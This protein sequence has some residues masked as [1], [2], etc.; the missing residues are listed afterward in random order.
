MSKET[1]IDRGQFTDVILIE[2]E[3]GNRQIRK[4]LRQEYAAQTQAAQLTNEYKITK[5]LQIKGLRKALSFTKS[6]GRTTLVLEYVDGISL[7]TYF[8]RGV[9]IA[10]FLDI[11]CAIMQVVVEMHQKSV[12]H[13]DLNPN[14]ILI[15]EAQKQPYIIDFGIASTFSSK[16][17]RNVRADALEG[18]LA[19]MA[20]E[21]TGR[22]NRIIDQRSDLYSLGVTFYELLTSKLPFFSNDPS[23]L[24]HAH[25]A[26][27]PI[28]PHKL[29]SQVPN[30]LS[31]LVIKLLAKSAEERYQSAFGVLE[32]LKKIK[33]NPIADFELAQDDFNST[34]A[35]KQKLYGREDELRKLLSAYTDVC[36]G[37][38]RFLTIGGY[39]GA[40]KS[41]LV[42]E[43]H[44]PVTESNGYFI[45]GKFDQFKRDIPYY[46]W[47]Q[48]FR[49][50]SNW[51]LSE[52]DAQ[53]MVWQT[54]IKEAVKPYGKMLTDLV[55]QL[56][57]LIGKQTELPTM[58]IVEFQSAFS[59]TMTQFLQVVASAEHPLVVFIDDVQWAD[60]ASLNLIK[61]ILSN[62]DCTHLLLLVAFRSN[63]IT[64]EH[65]L[66]NLFADLKKNGVETHELDLQNL[67]A[68]H[69]KELLE[70]ALRPNASDIDGL[71]EII[72]QKTQ[73]NAFFVTQFLKT[74][75]EC[76]LLYLDHQTKKWQWHIQD[77]LKLDITDNV[78]D[79]LIQKINKMNPKA[80]E[81]L[82]A[83]ACFG[84]RFDLN[85]LAQMLQFNVQELEESLGWALQEQLIFINNNSV[86]FA[87]DRIQQAFYEISHE[88]YRLQTHA[89]IGLFI[90]E[91]LAPELR[92]ARIFDYIDHL[93]K[94]V[95][96]LPADKKIWLAKL[97]LVASQRAKTAN[98]YK[99]ALNY[100]LM[101]ESLL[102]S[103]AWQKDYQTALKTKQLIA[104]ILLLKTKFTQ[105][106]AH[107]QEGLSKTQ[108]LEDKIAFHEIQIKA[109]IAQNK[110][111]KAVEYAR[112][113]LQSLGVSLP[114]NPSLIKVGLTLLATKLA[115]WGKSSEDILG[116]PRMSDPKKLAAMR[117]M[118][119]IDYAVYASQKELFPIHIMLQLQISLK[120]GNSAYSPMAYATFG[121]I[122]CGALK[123]IDEG[124][125][126][127]NTAL[128]LLDVVEGNEVK[129]M[130]YYSASV[131]TLHWKLHIL[132]AL[133]YLEAAMQTGR[134]TGDL[135][136][137][138]LAAISDIYYSIFASTNLQE[139]LEKAQ[140]HRLF[141]ESTKQ[142]S[143]LLFLNIYHTFLELLVKP[144]ADEVLFQGTYF[145]SQE[146]SK[147]IEGSKNDAL[148]SGYY[149]L[150]EMLLVYY[151]QFEKAAP[152]FQLTHKYREGSLGLF[153]YEL[154]CW[155]ETMLMTSLLE[156]GKINQAKAV[157]SI[158][159]NIKL[160]KGVEK[161][162]PMNYEHLR[163]SAEAE[164][165]RTQGDAASALRLYSKAI[166]LAA[167]NQYPF[168]E[169]KI[170]ERL[171]E[172]LLNRK[173]TETGE[174]HL[175]KAFELYQNLGI[176]GKV[177]ALANAYPSLLSMRRGEAAITP[178]MGTITR[179]GTIMAGGGSSALDIN[180]IIKAS[181]ILSGEVMR[182]RLIE[183]LMQLVIEN[184]GAERGLLFL[185]QEGTLTVEA[186]STLKGTE[187]FKDSTLSTIGDASPE[188]KVPE[189]LINYTFR[190]QQTVLLGDAA[191]KGQF[192]S[193]SYI[194]QNK[195][196]SVLCMPLV[197]QGKVSGVLY[198]ENNLSTDFFTDS[199]VELLNMLSTQIAISLE[200][201]LL[202][203]N[204]EEKVKARTIEV[205]KQKSEI[206]QQ[207][208]ELEKQN[209]NIT[210]SI[211]YAKRIQE[212]MLPNMDEINAALPKNFVYFRPRDIV[213]GDFY[214]FQDLEDLCL[215]AAVDCTG[216]GVPGAFMSLIG[217]DLLHEI[218]VSRRIIE[219][220]QI[221]KELHKGVTASLRQRETDNRD[222]MDIA[223]CVIHRQSPKSSTYSHLVF[224]GAHNPLVYIQ[225]GTLQQI[226]G[227]NLSIG[228]RTLPN[229]VVEYEATRID[230]TSPT[231]FYIFSD[232][233]QDQFGGKEGR[234]FMIKRMK[235][236]FEQVHQL[237]HS[238]Q[239]STLDREI[240]AWKQNHKQT[241]DILVIG[242]EIG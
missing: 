28:P 181:E 216:H 15:N 90:Y 74:L 172:L 100:S 240:S 147:T 218:V 30:M 103:D 192:T 214:W 102:P 199:R 183:K 208:A 25:L 2:D 43:I 143:P 234:K 58:N 242:F 139:L 56:E 27:V 223:L 198:L 45:E 222:G 123:Q 62:K 158:K 185:N 101:A 11:A 99:A 95:G 75:D 118:T 124:Y 73:G 239:M 57:L 84:N 91:Q 14:N 108:N 89:K 238:E 133:P 23:E 41:S 210:A 38:A 231:S 187:L 156:A 94:A 121:G 44:K 152:L 196:K 65:P 197:N 127:A 88:E 237:P 6:G 160:L 178:R 225:N 129:A 78:V 195:P 107:I 66:N 35:L 179:A 137:A 191:Y 164:L 186:E 165:A 145:A 32:D 190:S 80:L 128:K 22:I 211:N 72:L 87:H 81:T 9:S 48:A 55:P 97:N 174:F 148:K 42:H 85:A 119:S 37:Q 194:K 219:P 125:K 50:L 157:S 120:Y 166:E 59:R 212:A 21:Q 176:L 7:N 136:F 228:G 114:N 29:V 155:L 20:P 134:T 204:L 86:K 135:E 169:C 96:F 12:I 205:M 115:L 163:F 40:G 150:Y 206:E 53:L 227:S 159:K 175:Q 106:E 61:A 110:L 203:E 31:K 168:F 180:T 76:D 130:T 71:C 142:E 79:L 232:G 188:A 132:D 1:I 109:Y 220:N 16:S 36:N 200:N 201:A 34:F 153:F 209:H 83:G 207:R 112:P 182:S 116:L 213:S 229:V 93:N 18:T 141:L 69:V 117:I 10:D 170:R 52:K 193:L 111:G 140:Q 68:P 47:Q 236:I 51:L 39:S 221:L 105:S 63:E 217:N 144:Q 126:L 146:A 113:V 98:A 230:L 189:A 67:K 82:S 64:P 4:V 8:K 122:L 202:Y 5:D 46:A 224:A 226:K 26:Q 241:D 171:A 60:N 70:D 17:S 177:N 19:Y 173:Q 13:K 235:G 104:E 149:M 131:L 54:K 167:K 33:Q 77:I 92:E 154:H 184:A 3:S 151:N 49:E 162:A 161:N 138:S 24:V 233:F 215:I